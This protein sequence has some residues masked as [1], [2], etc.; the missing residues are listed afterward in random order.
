MTRAEVFAWFE[1]Q[2]YER[3]AADRWLMGYE[4]THGRAT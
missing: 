4:L 2:G 3:R 1:R